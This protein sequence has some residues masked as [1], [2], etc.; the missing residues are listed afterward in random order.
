MKV[1]NVIGFHS[2][3]DTLILSLAQSGNLR[4]H[5]GSAPGPGVGRSVRPRISSYAS[6][7]ALGRHQSSE[8]HRAFVEEL[9]KAAEKCSS[10]KS[11]PQVAK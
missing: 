5:P 7:G 6:F 3:I 4:L 9:T 2:Q 11:Y 8:F 10:G 1:R